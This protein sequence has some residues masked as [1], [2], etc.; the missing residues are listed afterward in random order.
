MD[1]NLFQYLLQL[2]DDRLVLGSR[3]AEWCGHGPILE[4][5]IALTNISLDLIG[6]AQAL[7]SLAGRVENAGRDEDRLAYFR[8]SCDYRNCLIC[9]LP[10]GDF[11]FTIMRQFLFSTYSYLL[12]EVLSK[13][14]IQELA[15][16]AAK[17]FKE[18]RYHL[19]HSAEWVQRLGDGT[20]ESHARCQ[21]AL[22]ELWPY[23]N[24]MLTESNLEKQLQANKQI[25]T[26][27]NIRASWQQMT[28]EVLKA[29]TLFISDTASKNSVFMPSGGRDGRHTEHLGHLLTEMQILPRSYPDA[30]W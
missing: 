8:D 2:A 4:E 3:L 7:L 10:K 12:F 30:R 20:E 16:I 1:T 9:E 23:C 17:A 27:N 5:D 28:E 15:G 6:H 13:A 18:T 26:L 21:A 19:T 24:E 11:G 29:A 22:Q 25:P 14:N